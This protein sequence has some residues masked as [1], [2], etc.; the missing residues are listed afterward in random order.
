MIKFTVPGKPQAK[1]R[2]R[3]SGGHAY[4]PGKT[5]A[6][7]AAVAW[8]YKAA[9]VKASKQ[10]YP[11]DVPLKMV[12]T[13][14]MP[15]PSSR[16][17]YQREA[18]LGGEIRPTGRPDWDNIGKIISDALNG[19]AYKDDAQIVDSRVIKVYGDDPCVEVEIEEVG[20]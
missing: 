17:K 14:H 7:E 6:Y 10:P 1:A 3:F 5:T 15:I 20:R 19:I 9:A 11:G 18:M 12:V 4:T 16:P 2:P 13:A 8:A